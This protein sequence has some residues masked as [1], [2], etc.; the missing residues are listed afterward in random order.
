MCGSLQEDNPE[1]SD[2]KNPVTT[3]TRLPTSRDRDQILLLLFIQ[4]LRQIFFL[5]CSNYTCISLVKHISASVLLQL[6]DSH[7]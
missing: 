5:T 2:T 7:T 6:G 3:R 1:S 4:I